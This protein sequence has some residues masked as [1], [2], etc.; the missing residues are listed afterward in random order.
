[1]C[2]WC[3]GYRDTL[4]QL[5][6]H[7]SADV[8][9]HAILGGLAPDTDSPM[10]DD[11]Q[12]QIRSNWKR[13]QETIPG[14]QFNYE[15]WTRCTPRRST[16]LACRAVLTASK[17]Q[18]QE[19]MNLAVQQAY[20]LQARNPSDTSV[21][22]ELAEELG[23][24]KKDFHDKL[25]SDETEQLLRKHIE[26]SHEIGA[27]SFPTLFFYKDETFFPLVL[28]YTNYQITLDHLNSLNQDE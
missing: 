13:I 9:Y 3:W 18:L 4:E 15:F 27:D 19:Q 5:K 22:L 7:L 14:V 21:L 2:S 24:D 20:Y 25:I 17:Y 28:D 12:L 1:M 8:S 23:I 26:F 10:P 11:M 6:Q 16:Y